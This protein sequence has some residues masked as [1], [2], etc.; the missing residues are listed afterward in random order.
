[1]LERIVKIRGGEF[2]CST[3][4]TPQP[5]GSVAHTQFHIEVAEQKPAEIHV[6]FAPNEEVKRVIVVPRMVASNLHIRCQGRHPV[7][8]RKECDACDT[9]VKLATLRRNCF[10]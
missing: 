6:G 1:M 4:N 5:A 10:V 8:T 7:I 3:C 2:T 9:K